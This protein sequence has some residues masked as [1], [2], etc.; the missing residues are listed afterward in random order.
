MKIN[1]K[2]VSIALCIMISNIASAE[3]SSKVI[4]SN[5]LT[6]FKWGMSEKQFM[7][8]ERDRYGKPLKDKSEN[9]FTSTDYNLIADLPFQQI[10]RMRGKQGLTSINY[11]NIN[12]KETFKASCQKIYSFLESNFSSPSYQAIH[13]DGT[14]S[15]FVWIDLKGNTIYEFCFSQSALQTIIVTVE[16]QWKVINCKLEN[17]QNEYH[18][19]Y[20]P[21]NND[22]REFAQNYISIVFKPKVT[23]N[24]IEFTTERNPSHVSINQKD[25][26]FSIKSQDGKIEKGQCSF[27]RQ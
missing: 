3:E 12:N 7:S 26:R 8:V 16:P 27:T 15:F 10:V 14:D 4:S 20:E 19:F 11:M 17:S 5:D 13:K 1:N 25:M 18:Y 22:V 2:I 21:V 9:I 24:T 6:S 23:A